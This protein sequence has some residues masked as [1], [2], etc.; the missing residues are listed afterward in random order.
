MFETIIPNC[1]NCGAQ[2]KERKT[3]NNRT[4]W[5]CPNWRQDGR[6]CLGTI[7]D[8]HQEEERKR[9]FPRV[10]IRHNVASRSE[11][12][13]FRTVEIFESGDMR[14]NCMAG[15]MS[16]FCY[17]QQRTGK[18]LKDLVRKVEKENKVDFDKL[19]LTEHAEIRS[20]I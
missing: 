15:D 18:W 19:E 6:G 5:A 3:K 4:I 14:C 16:K 20:K 11:K 7:Y 13:K 2:L 8:P 10:V 17:H 1:N 12:G 9:I